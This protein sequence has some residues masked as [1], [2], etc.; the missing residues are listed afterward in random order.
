MTMKDCTRI[1]GRPTEIPARP[2]LYIYDRHAT[3]VKQ[4][5]SNNTGLYR[6]VNSVFGFQF[7]DKNMG[8]LKSSDEADGEASNLS[9]ENKTV[10]RL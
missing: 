9:L 2:G 4:N 3:P 7:G 5:P 10:E 6:K 8:V 1:H